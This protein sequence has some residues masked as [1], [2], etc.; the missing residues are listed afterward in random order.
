MGKPVQIW[1][2]NVYETTNT[3]IPLDNITTQV[4]SADIRVNNESVLIAI[5]L[6]NCSLLSVHSHALLFTCFITTILFIIYIKVLR[7]Q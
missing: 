7:F 3:V 6:C 1:C 2:K 4:L 5:P